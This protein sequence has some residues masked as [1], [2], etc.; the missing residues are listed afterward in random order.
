MPEAGLTAEVP[1]WGVAHVITKCDG[2]L[3]WLEWAQAQAQEHERKAAVA[4]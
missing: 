1:V 2:R 3:A 4:G